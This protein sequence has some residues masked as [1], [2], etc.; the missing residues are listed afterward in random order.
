MNPEGFDRI[1]DFLRTGELSFEC[2]D[3]HQIKQ[4][5][6]ALEYF[7][8]PLPKAK[9]EPESEQVLTWDP[10]FCGEK[11]L[12]SNENRTV[13]K[14]EEDSD[15]DSYYGVLGS[16]ACEKYRVRI[17]ATGVGCDVDIGFAPKDKFQ[18][19]SANYDACGWYFDG[20]TGKLYSQD[21]DY[22]RSYYDKKL[23][24]GNV[25]T[26][27]WNKTT[28]EISFEVDGKLLG[29][30][31]EGVDCEKDLF[32]AVAFSGKNVQLTLVP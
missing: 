5:K 26:C 20:K 3:S 21:G 29:V 32:P 16:V 30:A 31:F 19:N 18:C 10:E 14:R 15:D 27:L 24:V 4:L 9:S 2:L 17:D 8:I 7:Q 1:L 28:K 22:Y 13:R 11:L 12:L 23:Q 6:K 25:V